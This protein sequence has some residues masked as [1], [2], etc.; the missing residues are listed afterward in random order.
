MILRPRRCAVGRIA[1]FSISPSIGELGLSALL[2]DR[3]GSAE[4]KLVAFSGDYNGKSDPVIWQ[5][6]S[7]QI[8]RPEPGEIM[9]TSACFSRLFDRVMG[10]GFVTIGHTSDAMID[11][12]DEFYN[13]K[14]CPLPP[15]DPHKTRPRRAW[16][17]VIR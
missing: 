4:I 5:A 17:D 1:R 11:P 2:E 15:Y 14:L 12:Q 10:L 16:P 13:L 8:R 3:E 9:V 6:S 7:P